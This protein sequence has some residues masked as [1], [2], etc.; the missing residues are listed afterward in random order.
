MTD[1]SCDSKLVEN[2]G[3]QFSDGII[4]TDSVNKRRQSKKI[5][6]HN[7]DMLGPAAALNTNSIEK[8]GVK[9]NLEGNDLP[10]I[11]HSVNCLS[12]ES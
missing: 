4:T 6:G 9:E 1:P 5:N 3:N 10:E 2:T 8:E 7:K 11:D 12:Q